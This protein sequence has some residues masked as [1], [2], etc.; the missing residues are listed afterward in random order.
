MFMSFQIILM[1][2]YVYD[3]YV[4]IFVYLTHVCLY[5]IIWL[6]IKDKIV[7]NSMGIYVV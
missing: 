6:E 5:L 4:L 7:H 1:K 3:K 2:K